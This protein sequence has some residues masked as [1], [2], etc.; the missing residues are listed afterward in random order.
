MT[1]LSRRAFSFFFCSIAIVMKNRQ[2][3]QHKKKSAIKRE[4]WERTSQ[5]K[6]NIF[7]LSR[8]EFMVK[9]CWNET[10]KMCDMNSRSFVFASSCRH[11]LCCK[12]WDFAFP[13]RATRHPRQI[14]LN[15]GF[16][17]RV[18]IFYTK[19]LCRSSDPLG[20]ARVCTFS[21]RKPP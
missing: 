6:C 17:S 2:K 1:C 9:N 15:R 13:E 19:T 20:C 21:L 8:H 16:S 14:K 4:P 12:M 18:I 7:S 3:E 10:G 11:F 5:P